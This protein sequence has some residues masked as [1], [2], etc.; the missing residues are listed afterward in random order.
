MPDDG[1]ASPAAAPAP[2]GLVLPWTR[3]TFAGWALGFVLMLL[4]IGASGAVGL[5]DAQFPVGLGMGVGVGALQGR[6]LATRGIPPGAWLRAT[7]LGVVM[8]FVVYD[9]V[10]LVA[11]DMPFRLPALVVLGGVTAGVLQYR[12]VRLYA[13]AAWWIAASTAGWTLAGATVVFNDRYLPRI[14]GIAGALLF[15]AVI[16]FGGVALGLV[17]GLALDRILGRTEPDSP[18]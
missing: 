5:G 2:R 3:A 4:I 14:P 10:N 6:L 17:G 9:L 16:L 12:L 15:V 1:A 11:P 8:P 18:A 13:G 7:T